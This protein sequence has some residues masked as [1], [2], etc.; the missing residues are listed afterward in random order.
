MCSQIHGGGWEVIAS[1]VLRPQP[2][3]GLDIGRSAMGLMVESRDMAHKLSDV[4]VWTRCLQPVSSMWSRRAQSS[5]TKIFFLVVSKS[6]DSSDDL[7][8]LVLRLFPLLEEE[9]LS[10]R[11]PERE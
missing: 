8:E 1:S 3:V 4:R 11:Y 6:L 5:T 2:L 7:I 9:R 10:A